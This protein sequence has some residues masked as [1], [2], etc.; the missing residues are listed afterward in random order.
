MSTPARASS[1]VTG[2]DGRSYLV[3]FVL[4][5]S[6]FFLWGLAHSLLDIL[7][8]HFQEILGVTKA[9]SGLVQTAVYDIDSKY[10]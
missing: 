2:P 6:L 4:V 3:P 10:K 1:I 9:Q 7:N 8:K 5:T